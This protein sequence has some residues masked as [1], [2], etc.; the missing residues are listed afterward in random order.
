M[1]ENLKELEE[2]FFTTVSV[3]DDIDVIKARAEQRKAAIDAGEATET[4]Q[5]DDAGE[6]GPE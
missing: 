4:K 2:T 6:A 5:I 3:T 1:A